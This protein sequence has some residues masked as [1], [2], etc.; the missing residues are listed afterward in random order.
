VASSQATIL[1]TCPTCRKQSRVFEH[2]KGKQASCPFCHN[3]FSVPGPGA[4]VQ[5]PQPVV[6]RVDVVPPPKPPPVVVFQPVIQPVVEAREVYKTC[7][8][9]GE[10]VLDVAKKCKHCGETIDVALRA[11]EEAKRM[12]QKRDRS[13]MVF[14]N[15][16]GGGGGA[17]S[18]ASSAAASSSSTSR[19]LLGCF[20]WLMLSAVLGLAVCCC[21]PCILGLVTSPPSS[22]QDRD[23]PGLQ[24]ADKTEKET[25]AKTEKE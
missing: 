6:G 16:G 12:A 25:T 21:A 2:T 10:N 7:P 13:P 24:N 23:K 22:R 19:P 5:P 18:S 20:G 9:C 11:A 1:V 8:F 14:M 15:A 3:A 4:L 17:A